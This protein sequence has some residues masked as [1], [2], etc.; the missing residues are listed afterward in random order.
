MLVDHS[1]HFSTD[2]LKC[3]FTGN[4]EMDS[5]FMEMLESLRVI[6][7]KPMILSSAY[8]DPSHPR[9]KTKTKPG[10]HAKG[11][12]VDVLCLGDDAHRLLYLAI[13]LGFKGIG[14]NQRGEQNQRF[15]HLD[16]RETRAIWSY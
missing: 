8:R 13:Q 12:A 6:Y 3:K 10:M 2:E 4:C 15:I 14:V 1:E 9:E 11:R 16:N 5:F 7:D